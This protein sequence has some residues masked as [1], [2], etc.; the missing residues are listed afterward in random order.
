MK[1]Y[2]KI[3]ENI[4]KRIIDLRIIKSKEI[5]RHCDK[6][7]SSIILLVLYLITNCVIENPLLM[8]RSTGC[9]TW[10]VASQQIIKIK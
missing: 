3:I 8:S 7:L 4:K 9:S 6:Y 10:G 5:Y 2:E 1:G